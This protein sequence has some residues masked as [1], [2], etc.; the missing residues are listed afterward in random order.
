[1]EL[2]EL[3]L[4]M[5][6]A[7]I[8]KSSLQSK[9]REFIQDAITD[10]EATSQAVANAVTMYRRGIQT[11]I[12]EG[13][14]EGPLE[15]KSRNKAVNNIINDTSRLTRDLLGYTVKCTSRKGGHTYE[16]FEYTSPPKSV[17]SPTPIISSSS[18]PK[19]T[20]FQIYEDMLKLHPNVVLKDLIGAHGYEKIGEMIVP[21]LKKSME[22]NQDD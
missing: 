12:E 20:E 18:T 19:S 5:T 13:K 17:T 4:G 10:Y 1:M 3:V 6:Q 8:S 2:E 15:F 9:I 7:T 14:A 11:W 21:I 16:A 22:D